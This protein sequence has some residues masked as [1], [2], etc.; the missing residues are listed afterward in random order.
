MKDITSLRIRNNFAAFCFEEQ[1]FAGCGLL[2]DT[3][4]WNHEYG[5]STDIVK[6]LLL[7]ASLIHAMLETFQSKIYLLLLIWI[8]LITT[9][10]NVPSVKIKSMV[11]IQDITDSKT[12]IKDSKQIFDCIASLPTPGCTGVLIDKRWLLTLRS[13][14]ENVT[15][16]HVT[17]R[18]K[19]TPVIA[20][21]ILETVTR[22]RFALLMLENAEELRKISCFELPQDFHSKNKRMEIF[23]PVIPKQISTTLVEPLFVSKTD[24][25]PLKKDQITDGELCLMF[26]QPMSHRACQVAIGVPV[27]ENSGGKRSTV[28]ALLERGEYCQRKRRVKRST[29]RDYAIGRELSLSDVKWI[30][31]VR[32]VS[33]KII[34]S[35]LF[36]AKFFCSLSKYI[37]VDW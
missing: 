32:A 33:G 4:A 34:F 29:Q 13:C 16:Q 25:C 2:V 12:F 18:C 9:V 19:E 10:E 26:E 31:K 35:L 14:A 37:L 28:V 22:G 27:A 6:F 5:I 36:V 1:S 8:R 17:F 21:R 30:R 7:V 23:M 11:E 24:G 15:N 20:V 3:G